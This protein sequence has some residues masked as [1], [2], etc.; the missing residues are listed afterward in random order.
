MTDRRDDGTQVIFRK[1]WASKPDFWLE[2]STCPK[3]HKE[4]VKCLAADSSCEEYSPVFICL[5]CLKEGLKL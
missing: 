5:A 2:D 4:N 1:E 3:C